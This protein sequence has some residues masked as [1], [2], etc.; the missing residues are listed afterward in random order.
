MARLF[1]SHA[2]GRRV[3]ALRRRAVR[4]AR[5]AQPQ[6]R[7]RPKRPRVADRARAARRPL[8]AVHPRCRDRRPPELATQACIDHRPALWARSVLAGNPAPPRT[9]PGSAVG[10]SR[11]PGL[12]DHRLA[13]RRARYYHA[14]PSRV[15][16]RD[17]RRP[18]RA[19]H[20]SVPTLRR[21][22]LPVRQFSPGLSRCRA[23]QGCR[24]RGRLA[25]LRASELCPA[26]RGF[27]S[28]SVGARS[29]PQCRGTRRWR[30]SIGNQAAPRSR[31]AS[32][33]SLPCDPR[34]RWRAEHA[35]RW[36]R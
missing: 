25:R 34:C 7:Q 6:S 22:T 15:P 20:R 31:S 5:L 1:R 27:R 11:R 32:D 16:A 36:P 3:R 23:L 26:A 30:R 4:Q 19:P 18:Q 24:H 35:N 10:P 9:A 2:Q 28:L 17:R 12:G 14:P 33:R 13:G 21:H 29:H 8:G